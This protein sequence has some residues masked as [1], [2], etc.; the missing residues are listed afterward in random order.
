MVNAIKRDKRLIPYLKNEI[1][2][3]GMTVEV[4]K[5]LS[6]DEYAVIKVDAYFSGIMPRQEPKAVDFVVVVD[7]QCDAF[8]MYIL[9][10]KNVNKRKFLNFEDIQEKFENT[11]KIFLSDHFSDIFLND[12]FKYKGVKLYLVSDAYHQKKYFASH[13]DYL[14]Y[15]ERIN[16]RNTLGVDMKLAMKVFQFR[17]KLYRIEYE[18]PPNPIIRR[19]T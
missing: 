1:T 19:W 7:C 2:D 3:S 9:E 17:G 13:D 10:L 12:R 18:I 14:K 4:S 15:S 8:Y 5:D 16:K 11:I 6:V